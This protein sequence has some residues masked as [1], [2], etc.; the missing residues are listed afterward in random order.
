MDLPQSHKSEQK[1]VSNEKAAENG[2][3]FNFSEHPARKF[4]CALTSPVRH[5]NF[6]APFFFAAPERE[7]GKTRTDASCLTL[8]FC[9]LGSAGQSE[10]G[11]EINVP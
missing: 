3:E 10:K 4:P 7:E 11:S 1:K 5:D 2:P 6:G 9:A 8:L